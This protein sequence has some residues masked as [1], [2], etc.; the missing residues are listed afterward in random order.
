MP[1]W[2]QQIMTWLSLAMLFFLFLLSVLSTKYTPIWF[3]K[4]NRYCFF[5]ILF[6]HFPDRGPVVRKINVEGRSQLTAANPVW[7]DWP[8]QKPSL[9][10]DKE[11]AYKPPTP[12]PQTAWSPTP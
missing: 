11:K 5:I 4:A 7:K 2:K 9:G 1:V 3:S 12:E 6:L 8:S 10:R